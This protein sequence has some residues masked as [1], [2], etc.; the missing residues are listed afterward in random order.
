MLFRSHADGLA[1]DPDVT[2]VVVPNREWVRKVLQPH[3]EMVQARGAL[4]GGMFGGGMPM[5]VIKS[6][7]HFIALEDLGVTIPSE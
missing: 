3:E 4:M 2:T 5:S 7:W 6:P 1:L